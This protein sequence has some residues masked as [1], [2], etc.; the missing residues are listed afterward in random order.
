MK[1]PK[2][3]N[4]RGPVASEIIPI[5][6]LRRPERR[7]KTE[8]RNPTVERDTPKLRRYNGTSE[9]VIPLPI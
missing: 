2:N 7:C 9:P 5:G 1:T 3:T 8:Y 4:M 6:V